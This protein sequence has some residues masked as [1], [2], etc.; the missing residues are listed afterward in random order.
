MIEKI[1]TLGK[2][3]PIFVVLVIAFIVRL[4]AAVFSKG[5]GFD[6]EHFLYVEM[7]NSW[8]DNIEY[9]NISNS[10]YNEPQGVSLFYVSLNYLWFSFLKLFGISNPQW[11]MF[12]SR[13]LHALISLIVISFGY[14]I[15]ELISDK[16]NAVMVAW[17]LALYWFMPYISVHNLASFVSVPFLM[18]A[19]LIILRQD[20]NRKENNKDNIH[21][22]SFVIAGFFLG[23]AFST[24]YQCLLFVI[25]IVAALMI[26]KNFKNSLMTLIGFVISVSVVQVIPDLIVWGRPFAELQAFIENSGN[27]IFS[28]T[29]NSP[30]IYYSFL[31][32]IIGLVIPVSIMMLWGFFRYWKKHLLLFLPTLLFLLYY[33]VFPNTNGIYILP[34][35]PIFIILGMAGWKEYKENSTFWQRNVRLH[36]Y[37]TAFSIFVNFVALA[38]T[39]TT[40][41]NKAEVKA[42]THISKDKDLSSII[43]E[44]KVSSTTDKVP[45]FYTRNWAECTIL[46]KDSN[47]HDIDTDV[48]YVI[49]RE[50][51]DLEKRVEDMKAHLPELRYE[52]T[53]KPHFMSI[54]HNWLIRSENDGNMIVY[55]NCK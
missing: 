30:W 14:R 54:F 28:S 18:Y 11:L 39:S 8:I 34:I 3:H 53:Y 35:L 55:K 19:S 33:T 29:P 36:R 43:I 38:I 44:D 15:A 22:S 5:Y 51:K 7:P 1:S 25:G 50:S 10:S 41:S 21:R 47:V 37:L 6:H 23:L 17:A 45:L 52:A 16:K 12:F 31:M 40:F 2:K 20:I 26:L 9:Q 48:D 46:N 27:Y 49:F 42:L 13:L 4:V 24:W 32:I